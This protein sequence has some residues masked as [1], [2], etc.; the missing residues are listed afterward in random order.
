MSLVDQVLVV[1]LVLWA[2]KGWLQGLI[3]QLASLAGFFAGLFLA[4]LLYRPLTSLIRPLLPIL[5]LKALVFASI[6]AAVWLVGEAMGRKLDPGDGEQP[7]WPDEVGGALLG[8]VSGIAVL[9]S[10][11]VILVWIGSPMVR[12]VRHSHI[13]GWLLSFVALVV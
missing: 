1:F 7:D 11:L 5:G 3:R 12:T 13:G 10:G 4:L 2:L 6:L 8:V 9:F